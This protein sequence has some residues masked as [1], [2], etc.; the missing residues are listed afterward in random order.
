VSLNYEHKNL[1]TKQ[2]FYFCN[3]KNDKQKP[4]PQ[5]ALLFVIIPPI[6]KM[7][8]LKEQTQDKKKEP[9]K[10]QKKRE[11]QKRPLQ[12]PASSATGKFDRVVPLLFDGAPP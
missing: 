10:W 1:P 9:T 11:R 3:I 6:F 2:P 7:S 4:S 8:T 5:T 12:Q